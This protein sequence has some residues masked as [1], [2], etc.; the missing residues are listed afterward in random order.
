MRGPR[1]EGVEPAVPPAVGRS[2]LS[3]SRGPSSPSWISTRPAVLVRG[4][5]IGRRP[6]ARPTRTPCARRPRPEAPEAPAR[7]ST[8]S[9]G[10]WP[11]GRDH[12]LHDTGRLGGDRVVVQVGLLDGPVL[13]PEGAVGPVALRSG[14]EHPVPRRDPQH[15]L[16]RR[17]EDVPR[18]GRRRT[19]SA[20]TPERS[21]A[22]RSSRVLPFRR[23]WA[24]LWTTPPTPRALRTTAH[25]RPRWSGRA[26]S[27]QPSIRRPP[28]R[29]GL[30]GA[31][32]AR[33]R[34]GWPTREPAASAPVSLVAATRRDTSHRPEQ[35]IGE[36]GARRSR[37]KPGRRNPRGTAEP[38][39]EGSGSDAGMSCATSGSAR[40]VDVLAV[41]GARQD[42]RAGVRQMSHGCASD[43]CRPDPPAGAG[44]AERSYDRCD[45]TGD[46]HDPTFMVMPSS[47]NATRSRTCN[48]RA[49]NGAT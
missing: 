2:P 46:R 36:P 37:A 30:G 42:D 35:V 29:R 6:R 21:R 25:P 24:A 23:P 43:R 48:F 32:R 27:S 7:R 14:A 11:T 13:Q 40:I 3:R 38:H 18:P 17:P 5:E 22:R 45:S 28:H 49:H 12:P 8:G 20:P 16:R 44:P 1:L 9:T 41:E 31:A 10:R 15:R 47:A 39:E 4:R 19:P 26:S 33:E 34:S